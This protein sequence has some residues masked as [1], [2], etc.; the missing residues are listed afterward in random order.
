MKLYN[1]QRGLAV[2][3]IA[4]AGLSV[5][6]LLSRAAPVLADEP[7][8]D[9]E[10]QPVEKD[11]HEFMEYVFQPTYKRLKQSMAG[12]LAD[13]A[14]WKG[15]KADALS[16]AEGGNL[17]LMRLPDEDAAA[18][19]AFSAAVRESGGELYQ[20]AKKKD[21]VASKR[22]YELMLKNCNACHDKFAGGEHQLA[23]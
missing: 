20:S 6:N 17:L 10:P 13:N 7:A 8:A 12:E 23:P 15:V 19:A 4:L 16:L 9:V 5:G 11:M 22:H 1:L 14:V 21:P 3:V 2:L 18:W